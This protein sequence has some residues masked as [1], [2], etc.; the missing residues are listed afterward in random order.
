MPL[1]YVGKAMKS[2][3]IVGVSV[4]FGVVGRMDWAGGL[5]A[6]TCA[7][8]SVGCMR[9]R[10]RYG[11][12]LFSRCVNLSITGCGGVVV[13]WSVGW[14][15]V[16]CAVVSQVWLGI[17]VMRVVGALLR[18]RRAYAWASGLSARGCAV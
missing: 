12:C 6:S 13:I 14:S 5:P 15:G 9:R 16:R 17:A 10:C 1:W 7:T 2:K 18:I 8:Y 4:R 3:C 11:E